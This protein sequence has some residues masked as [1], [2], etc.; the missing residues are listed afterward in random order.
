MPIQFQTLLILN[1]QPVT[2]PHCGARTDFILD[3]SHTRSKIQVHRCLSAACQFEF[4]V[5]IEDENENE[6]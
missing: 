1:D 3:L 2:C 6:P 5:G 4:V